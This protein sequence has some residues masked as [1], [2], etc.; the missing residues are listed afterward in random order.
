[1]HRLTLA[2]AASLALTVSGCMTPSAKKSSAEGAAPA[3]AAKGER[4]QS[5]GKKKLPWWRL[6]QYSRKP[7]S[8]VRR[9]GDIRPGKGLLSNDEDGYVL[10]RKGEA[11]RSSDPTKP[12]KVKR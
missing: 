8:N 9:W 3:A 7:N 12:T 6:S 4:S 2:F 1:M 10:F 11:G 5:E